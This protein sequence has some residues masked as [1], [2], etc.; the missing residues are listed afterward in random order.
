MK[1][2]RTALSR[3]IAQRHPELARKARQSEV[4]VSDEERDLT[5]LL[6]T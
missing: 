4:L 3:H 6:L 2:R 5:V 1:L